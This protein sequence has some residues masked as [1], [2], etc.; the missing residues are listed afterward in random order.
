MDEDNI[1]IVA[2]IGFVSIMFLLFGYFLWP[3]E[4]T[5]QVENKLWKREIQVERWQINHHSG[6]SYPPNDAFNVERSRRQRGTETYRDA[7]GV[8]QSRTKTCTR[9]TY[10]TWYEYDVWEWTYNRSFITEHMGEDVDPFWPNADD[11]RDT[12]PTNPERLGAW[13]ET[14]T[15]IFIS[16]DKAYFWNT[17]QTTWNNIHVENKRVLKVNN[18]GAILEVKEVK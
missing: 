3:Y 1:P 10:D 14:Y 16:R 17:D 11:I 4:I 7:N 2:G 8:T 12:D 18:A 15:V 13:I 5:A 6:W 9:P